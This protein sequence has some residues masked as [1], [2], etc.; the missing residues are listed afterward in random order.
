MITANVVALDRDARSICDVYISV[1]TRYRERLKYD[2]Y[3]E[4]LTHTSIVRPFRV[5]SV[6]STPHADTSLASARPERA[7]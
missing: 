1:P 6:D 3:Q 7:I 5:H 4:M 2:R